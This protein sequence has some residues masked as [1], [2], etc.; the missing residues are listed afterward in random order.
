MFSFCT[1][2]HELHSQDKLG[3]VAVIINSWNSRWVYIASLFLAHATRPRAYPVHPGHSG[4]RLKVPHLD[5]NCHLPHTEGRKEVELWACH[6]C[7]PFFVQSKWCGLVWRQG[8]GKYVP[9]CTWKPEG[10][11]RWWTQPTASQ[12]AKC[13]LAPAVCKPPFRGTH[14]KIS[15]FS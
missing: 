8:E 12:N 11:G 9:S 13:L 10:Q 4:S 6:F 7:S 5:L 15:N 3:C 2:L 14:L 1:G